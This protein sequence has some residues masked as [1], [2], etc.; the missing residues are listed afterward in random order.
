MPKIDYLTVSITKNKS[1]FY[2]TIYDVL[3]EFAKLLP[4]L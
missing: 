4:D 2:L 1:V 3:C